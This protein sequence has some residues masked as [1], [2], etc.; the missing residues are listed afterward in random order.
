MIRLFESLVAF[1]LITGCIFVE[2]EGTS[3]RGP[4][5]GELI[6]AIDNKENIL[7]KSSTFGYVTIGWSEGSSNCKLSRKATRSWGVVREASS[8]WKVSSRKDI[9]IDPN[10]I[11]YE[12]TVAFIIKQEDGLYH[13]RQAGGSDQTLRAVSAI[14][15]IL[16]ECDVG[17][18]FKAHIIR[19]E[20]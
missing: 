18:D 6:F 20:R 1:L 7:M 19:E 2:R 15:T 14:R 3:L 4:V 8:N 17:V 12:V 13:I 16:N 10:L 5:P 11:I 9:A